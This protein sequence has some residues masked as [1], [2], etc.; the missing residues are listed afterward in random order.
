M[1]KI[2]S[3][4]VDS[5]K[6][7][8][9]GSTGLVQSGT[10]VVTLADAGVGKVLDITN[11]TLMN[12][13][14]TINTAQIAAN[15]ITRNVVTLGEQT[16]K[17]STN[18]I[19]EGA[20]VSDIIATRGF[21]LATT[22]VNTGSDIATTGLDETK[23]ISTELLKAVGQ[24]TTT[25]ISLTKNSLF[26]FIG[27]VDNVLTS[28]SDSI[29]ATRQKKKI[30]NYKEIYTQLRKSVYTTF[31]KEINNFIYNLKNFSNNQKKLFDVLI[32]IYKMKMCNP[33]RIYGYSCDNEE[34]MRINE[35]KGELNI[36]LKSITGK[37]IILNNFSNEVYNKM[38]T[39]SISISP[40][41]YE[42]K[43]SNIIN[44]YYVDSSVIFEKTLKNFN[45]LAMKLENAEK[46]Q[47]IVNIPNIENVQYVQNM[48]N[49]QNIE[50][51]ENIPNAS[52]GAGKKIYK[53]K[54]TY[55]KNKNKSKSNKSKKVKKSRNQ[56]S[57]KS[58]K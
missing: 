31:K 18:I 14:N 1:S 58:K 29:L 39:I 57:R 20:N 36:L 9:E 7:V 41:E 3:N 35:F 34:I 26:G 6:N 37:I 8:G 46:R 49:T 21:N 32:T 38:L 48:P 51:I 43:I 11:D 27:S 24:L 56:K 17:S 2:W 45:D 15:N 53:R 19:K 5:F 42:K 55:L 25:S 23:T 54:T 16:I 12:S 10:R 40:E 13:L 50:N 33:G 22:A 28:N 52:I 47:K 4:I 44:P 30:L